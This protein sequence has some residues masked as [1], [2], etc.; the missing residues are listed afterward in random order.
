[1][2]GLFFVKNKG[3]T[4]TNYTQATACDTK[5]FAKFFHAMLDRGVY[6]A[7][8]QYEALFL[9]LAHD[10]KTIEQTIH[11]AAAGFEAVVE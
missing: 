6:L 11:F 3:D 4:V 1:M 5:R 9:S 7:P 2:I 10:E 8:S